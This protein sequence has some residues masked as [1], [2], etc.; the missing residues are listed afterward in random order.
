MTDI[1]FKRFRERFPPIGDRE[2]ITIYEAYERIYLDLI[3]REFVEA[4]QFD[5]LDK[6]KDLASKTFDVNFYWGYSHYN[7]SHNVPTIIFDPKCGTKKLME[8]DDWYSCH[9][10]EV[11]IPSFHLVI[12]ISTGNR[13]RADLIEKQRD[14]YFEFVEGVYKLFLENARQPIISG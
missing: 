12:T 5:S 11:D 3:E 1:L 6:I 9:S 10:I 4:P 8:Y 2:R 14:K 7:M 13:G